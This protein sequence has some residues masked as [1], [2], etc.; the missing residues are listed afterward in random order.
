LRIGIDK[1]YA[2]TRFGVDR[3]EVDC[4]GGFTHTAFLIQH[5]NDHDLRNRLY[6][7]CTI[8]RFHDF[9]PG[10]AQQTGSVVAETPQNRIN[11]F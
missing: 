5:S 1:Q 4:D 2:L 9:V 11:D 8:A 3:R 6:Y 10:N 7:D